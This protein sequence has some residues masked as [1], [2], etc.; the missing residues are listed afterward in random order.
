MQEGDPLAREQACRRLLD[1]VS[2]KWSV[3]IIE[4]L[5]TGPLRFGKLQ[6]R[7]NG[8]SAKV[9]TATLRRLEEARLVDRIV[10]ADAPMHVEYSLTSDGRSAIVPLH[11]LHRWAEE[12]A[13]LGEALC[14][15]EDSKPQ[16]TPQS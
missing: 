2:G 11:A 1:L 13:A 6:R 3:L 9:L 10:Y 16:P 15:A 5:Q 8:V 4:S 12:H 7:V 14:K